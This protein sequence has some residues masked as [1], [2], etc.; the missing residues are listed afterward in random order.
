MWLSITTSLSGPKNILPQDKTKEHPQG[1]NQLFVTQ[2]DT[3]G[4][5]DP[6]WFRLLFLGGFPQQH[7]WRS[8]CNTLQFSYRVAVVLKV[9]LMHEDRVDRPHGPQQ[10]RS[11]AAGSHQ[12]V[13]AGAPR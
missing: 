13:V 11:F 7:H 8:R 4:C 9:V 5:G 6:R 2:V 3:A 1:L 10:V 12:H